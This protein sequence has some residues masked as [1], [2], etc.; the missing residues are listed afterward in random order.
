MK[1]LLDQWIGRNI[2]IRTVTMHQY[3]RL[4]AH[5][6][7]YVQL[8]DAHWLGSSARFGETLEHGLSPGAESEPFHGSVLVR[9][10]NIS[11]ICLWQGPL[12]DGAYGEE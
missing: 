4:V 9:V 11:D 12:P 1:C 6:H 3:G 2:L 7:V 8:D 5:D 10:D